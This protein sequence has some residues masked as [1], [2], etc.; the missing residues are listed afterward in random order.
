[1]THHMRVRKLCET[2]LVFASG[3]LLFK[4]FEMY[5]FRKEGIQ[6]RVVKRGEYDKDVVQWADAIISAGGR[7]F[8]F[9]YLGFVLFNIFFL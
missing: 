3:P 7:D 2:C 9:C 1:M 5:V 8:R 6:V 4:D